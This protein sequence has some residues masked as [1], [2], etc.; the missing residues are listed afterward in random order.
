MAARDDQVAHSD[1]RIVLDG[2]IVRNLRIEKGLTQEKMAKLCKLNKKTIENIES[3]RPTR[4]NTVGKIAVA[5]G[6]PADRLITPTTTETSPQSMIDDILER[7]KKL[8]L[9]EESLKYYIRAE[10]L[11]ATKRWTSAEQ[12]YKR[13]LKTCPTGWNAH[14][15]RFGLAKVLKHRRDFKNAINTMDAILDEDSTNARAHYNRACYLCLAGRPKNEVLEALGNAIRFSENRREYCEH[16][17]KD[18]DLEQMRDDHE[19]LKIV[20]TAD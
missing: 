8:E 2:K 6:V 17:L 18:D 12:F 9:R 11:R 16:A 13:S 3:G 15:A 14:I 7:L 10:E 4:P 5:L 1:T 19:F 20:L